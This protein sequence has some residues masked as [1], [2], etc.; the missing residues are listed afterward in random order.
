MEKR[1]TLGAQ[2]EEE[3]RARLWGQNGRNGKMSLHKT[4]DIAG[5]KQED[6]LW[7]GATEE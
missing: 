4:K 5:D 1:M 7:E 3:N 2:G 6:N